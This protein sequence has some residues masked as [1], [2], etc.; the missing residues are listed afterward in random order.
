M[1]VKALAE[2]TGLNVKTIRYLE[3]MEVITDPLTDDGLFFMYSLA[4][5]WKHEEFIRLQIAN[6]SMAR[7]VRLLFGSGYGKPERYMIHRLLAHYSD[8]E[9][10]GTYPLHIKQLVD[11]V[12]CYYNLP[13]SAR[14]DLTVKAYK[15]RKR[16]CNM[17]YKSPDLVAISKA[18]T[19][20]RKPKPSQRKSSIKNGFTANDIFGY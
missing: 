8:R 3:R 14:H 9:D 7:R 12:T 4:T 10:G 11:E 19:G 15:L 5:I 18:L 6:L 13:Q 20:L 16:I 2:D 17:R 1:D